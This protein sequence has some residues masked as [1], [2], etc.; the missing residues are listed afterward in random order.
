MVHRK[1][2]RFYLVDLAGSERQKM[3]EASGIRLKE[4]GCINKSLSALGNVIKVAYR[5]TVHLC[6]F[7]AIHALITCF[8]IYRLWLMRRMESQDMFH[9]ETPS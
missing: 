4:A 9:I 2:S 8:L 1:I 3:S 7:L 6:K 5:I